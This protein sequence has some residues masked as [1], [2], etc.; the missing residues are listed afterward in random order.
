MKKINAAPRR[1]I[2]RFE[3]AAKKLRDQV[4]K[5]PS[6]RPDLQGDLHTLFSINEAHQRAVFVIINGMRDAMAEQFEELRECIHDL[7]EDISEMHVRQMRALEKFAKKA[8]EG[9]MK[10]VVI[11][12]F[13]DP[14]GF[15]TVDKNIREISIFR[16]KTVDGTPVNVLTRRVSGNKKY[17]KRIEQQGG[18]EIF[19][20]YGWRGQIYYSY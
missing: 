15:V 10:K 4:M 1:R 12:Q 20:P 5:A 14:L 9:K 16:Q 19:T 6:S 13:G 17:W 3:E 11:D 2:L 8:K 18:Y 7:R